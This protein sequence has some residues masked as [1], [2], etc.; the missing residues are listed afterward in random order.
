[1][2]NYARGM[3]RASTDADELT[4]TWCGSFQQVAQMKRQK[5]PSQRSGCA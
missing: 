2:L 3:E 4:S 5:R 1:M